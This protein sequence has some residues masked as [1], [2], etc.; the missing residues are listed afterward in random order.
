MSPIAL[1]HSAGEPGQARLRET[2]I[3]LVDADREDDLARLVCG[4]AGAD[5]ERFRRDLLMREAA[6]LM[7]L[8]HAA[9]LELEC[10]SAILRLRRRR[11]PFDV[12]TACRL[13]RAYRG[14]LAAGEAIL[15]SEP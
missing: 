6:P 3:T 15:A 1:P 2:V 8:C 10:F 11:I 5:V 13:L 7:E 9:R 14:M 4:R 12:G